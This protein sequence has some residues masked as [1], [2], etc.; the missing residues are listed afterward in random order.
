MKNTDIVITSS[1]LNFVYYGEEENTIIIGIDE[2]TDMI[3]AFQSANKEIKKIK[4]ANA[5]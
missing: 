1:K 3:E 4:L 2:D 5:K